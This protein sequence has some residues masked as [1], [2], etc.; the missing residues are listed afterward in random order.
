MKR[1]VSTLLA[2]ALVFSLAVCARAAEGF[3]FADPAAGVQFL[4]PEGW[5]LEYEEDAPLQVSFV[6]QG[7]CSALMQYGALADGE[8]SPSLEAAAQLLGCE[9]GDVKRLT[10]GG[11][12]YYRAA[13][14][15][16]VSLGAFSFALPVT[17]WLHWENGYIY[18]YQYAGSTANP[19]LADF[20][21]MICGAVYTPVTGAA[22]TEEVPEATGTVTASQEALPGIPELAPAVEE[23]L[24]AEETQA[25]E[26]TQPVEETQAIEETQA[27][28][29]ISY[30]QA[31]SAYE[32]GDYAQ[33]QILFSSLPEV[34]DS[35]R[36]LRLLRI[37]SAGG[38]TSLGSGSYQKEL[39]LTQADKQDIAAAAADFSFADTAQVLLCNPDVAAHY[40]A[41]HWSGGNY[42]TFLYFRTDVSG[43]MYRIGS[44][45]AERAFPDFGIHNG[46]FHVYENGVDTIALHLALTEAN[47]L[48]VTSGGQTFTLVRK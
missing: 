39:A 22:E 47:T 5:D 2:A 28:E 20:K 3:V 32:S 7:E 16:A 45:L 48:E 8:S 1:I 24:A 23:T 9:I 11:A 25:I 38:N 35:G 46:E 36:Y 26:E 10:M 29:E 44:N 40:L 12:E 13:F 19:L 14:D 27:A 21:A 15:Q 6:P 41:G 4:I 42:N 33:A 43:C 37:R 34:A 30:A 31:V 18:L 17:C